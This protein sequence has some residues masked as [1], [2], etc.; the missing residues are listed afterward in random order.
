M[1]QCIL[2][3][4]KLAYSKSSLINFPVVCDCQHYQIKKQALDYLGNFPMSI[5]NMKVIVEFGI[6]TQWVSCRVR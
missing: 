3:L 5:Y 4:V 1:T 6:L 2:C